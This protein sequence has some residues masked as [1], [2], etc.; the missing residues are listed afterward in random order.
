MDT[1]QILDRFYRLPEAR[2]GRLSS[3][4]RRGAATFWNWVRDHT[5]RLAVGAVAVGVWVIAHVYYYNTLLDL[6]MN[7]TA[8]RAQIGAS[9]QKRGHIQRNLVRLVRYYAAY[10]RGVMKD[11]TELRTAESAGDAV[12][13]QIMLARLDA[14]AEQYPK[15]EL[16]GT[17]VQFSQIIN[18]METEITER[19]VSYNEAVNVYTTALGQFPAIVFGRPLGFGPYE[20]YQ[21]KDSAVTEYREVE[22]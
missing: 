2:P 20:Y 10:E 7:V 13:A 18:E 8:A 9:E 3:L 22:P 17:V 5:P 6:E 16:G 21:P 12:P 11:L 19:I 4:L 15:L 14:V 1:R